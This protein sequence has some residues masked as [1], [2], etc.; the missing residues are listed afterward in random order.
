MLTTLADLILPRTC[1]ECR[2]PGALL[3][4]RCGPDAPPLLLAAGGLELAAAA[5]Y[6]DA[7]RTALLAYKERG[8]RD[9]AGVLGGLL[10]EAVAALRP[11]GQVRLVPVPSSAAARRERG[12]DHVRRLAIAAAR[13]GAP[14]VATPL[15]LVRDVHDSAGLGTAAREQNLAGALRA[16]PAR[17]DAVLVDAVLVDDIVTTGT[18]LLEAARA[19]RVAGW[20]VRGAA[21]VAATERRDGGGRLAARFT[22]G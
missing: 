9:L 10:A 17:A 1:I 5:R 21:V 2:A 15:R 14:P 20:T 19:L 22:R 3:C 8:R 12:G 7:V 11:G 13:R 18:T 16:A 4:A 6:D